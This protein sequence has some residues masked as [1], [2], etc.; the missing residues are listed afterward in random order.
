MINNMKTLEDKEKAIE[1]LF[2][3]YSEIQRLIIV[4]S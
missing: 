2:Q 3:N 4:P 1:A